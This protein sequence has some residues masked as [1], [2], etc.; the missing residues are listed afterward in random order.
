MNLDFYRPGRSFLHRLDPRA[1]LLFLAPLFVAFFLNVPA[2]LLLLDSAAIMAAV[3]LSLGPRQL[4][5]PLK[6]IGPVLILICL[7]TPPFHRGGQALLHVLGVTILTADG[8]RETLVMLLRFLGITFGFFG[9]VSTISMDDLVLSMRWFGLPY[10]ACLVMII[11]LRTIPSLA[12]T[13]HNVRDAH[14]L[15]ADPLAAGRR[16]RFLETWLPVLTSVLIEAVKGIPVL[17]MALESRGFGR[18]NP[19]TSFAELRRGRALVPDLLV[20]AGITLVLLCPAFLL[21]G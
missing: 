1:K 8:L 5:P 6:A 4:L 12:A 16:R 14:R 21:A 3:A 7:L 9:I 13:W 2:W 15:R 10:A 19:R 18:R 11:T 17:A 20:L